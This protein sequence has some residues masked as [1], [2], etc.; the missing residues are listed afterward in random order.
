LDLSESSEQLSLGKRL[1]AKGWR[2]G[3]LAP[4][5]LRGIVGPLSGESAQS[6]VVKRQKGSPEHV[7]SFEYTGKEGTNL[8]ICT[9]TCDIASDNESVVEAMLVQRID[10]ANALAKM[11]L[12]VRRFVIDEDRR[13]IASS[14]V[15]TLIAKDLLLA[16]EPER[17]CKDSKTTRDFAAWLGMR[18]T[19]GAHPDEYV[20]NVRRP[21]LAKLAELRAAR[22]PRMTSFDHCKVRLFPPD[23]DA[24]PPYEVELYFVLPDEAADDAQRAAAIRADLAALAPL[25]EASVM[26]GSAST[27][28]WAA[29]PLR[30]MSA[31][32]FLSTD[33]LALD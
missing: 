5:L 18:Y 23:I 4:P 25:L 28:S 9:Q 1:I 6:A 17:G 2:M 33:D 22:D 10:N 7:L 32:D 15:K 8:V 19:R 12:S 29:E 11:R 24:R 31:E 16:L 20:E 14:A 26:Q 3:V 30:S 21:I 13:L 27:F